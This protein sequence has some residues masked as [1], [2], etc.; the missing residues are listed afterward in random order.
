[1]APK[2]NLEKR[3][4]TPPESEEE[5]DPEEDPEEG[6]EEENDP[7]ELVEEI[8]E[9]PEEDP[10]GEEVNIIPSPE[11]DDGE[12]EEEFDYPD[13]PSESGFTVKP[14]TPKGTNSNS[15][16]N[17]RSRS[18][19]P[20]GEENSLKNRKKT[21]INE[22]EKKPVSGGG[23]R[24]WSEEDEIVVLQGMIDFEK[25]KTKL[26]S[27]SNSKLKFKVAFY[28]FI[29]SKLSVKISR[30]QLYDKVRRLKKKFLTNLEKKSS[31]NREEVPV[32]SKPH[33]EK[34]FLLSKKIWGENNLTNA[35]DDDNNV[36]PKKLGKEVE[37]KKKE[38]DAAVE[39][40]KKKKEKDAAMAMAM[41][42]DDHAEKKEK[43]VD[44]N[45]DFLVS[46]YPNL[47]D[48]FDY[49]VMNNDVKKT[50]TKRLS[51]VKSSEAKDLEEEWKILREEEA[52]I[53][54][55]KMNLMAKQTKLLLDARKNM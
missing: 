1:M 6:S 8:E 23:I 28:E 22:E 34:T 40:K 53:F 29:A 26:G 51:L 33:E 7:E 19:S 45:L 15:A 43:K 55:K 17:K 39:T 24:V 35:S 31:E 41:D 50:L 52:Q 48:S 32:F 2:K 27:H 54:L 13:S 11:S 37:K 30:N 5:E 38:K 46:K 9:D 20:K 36:N 18:E 14:I 16:I 12:G 3:P 25:E 44:K 42:I 49:N 21:K 10:E 47:I 4:P